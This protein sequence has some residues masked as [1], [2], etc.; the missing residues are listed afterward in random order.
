MI[1]EEYYILIKINA[2]RNYRMAFL[3]LF[4]LLGLISCCI[5]ASSSA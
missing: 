2:I 1:K 4:E 5:P 3:Y